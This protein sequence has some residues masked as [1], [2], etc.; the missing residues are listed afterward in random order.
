MGLTRQ[1]SRLALGAAKPTTPARCGRQQLEGVTAPGARAAQ[2]HTA[3]RRHLGPAWLARRDERGRPR[4]Q[5]ACTSAW[6]KGGV[7]DE[8]RDVFGT[9]PCDQRVVA[10]AA[11]QWHKIYATAASL[12]ASALGHYTVSVGK[13]TS[14]QYRQGLH[15]AGDAVAVVASLRSPGG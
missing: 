6:A 10:R 14:W 11:T 15:G 1:Q 12:S 5:N 3:P 9:H 2:P 4:R 13:P 8:M 7:L